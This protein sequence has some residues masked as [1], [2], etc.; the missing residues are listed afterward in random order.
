MRE[1]YLE[2]ILNMEINIK[3][4]ENNKIEKIRIM[5]ACSQIANGFYLKNRFIV[6][7][8]LVKKSHT[9]YLPFQEGYN[10]KS[11]WNYVKNKMDW[12]ED[13]SKFLNEIILKEDSTNLNRYSKW[14]E[15]NKK[16]IERSIN[17][18]FDFKDNINITVKVVSYGSHLS[19]THIINSNMT[20]T[21]RNDVD[22]EYIIEGLISCIVYKLLYGENVKFGKW[23]QDWEKNEFLVDFINSKTKINN[24]TGN[25]KQT[26]IEKNKLSLGEYVKDS[27]NYLNKLGF[28]YK[29]IFNI[30]NDNI[31][32]KNK[33]IDIFTDYESKI[34]KMLI[35]NK[36]EI[37][38]FDYIADNLWNNNDK[39]SLWTIAKHIQNIRNKIEKEGV[40][41]QIIQTFRKQGY[42]LND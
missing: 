7:P 36:N 14:W 10:D 40:N 26:L 30:N 17:S 20:I 25:I 22:Y 32:I 3:F 16:K 15:L 19:F 1:T 8:Y 41:P 11:Y 39:Y 31:L 34:L 29:N 2:F 23:Q 4:E 42:I 28:E 9:I 27:I 33:R 5:Q 35:I 13:K 38:K 21:I 6:L 24:I 18:V 12:R 37:V